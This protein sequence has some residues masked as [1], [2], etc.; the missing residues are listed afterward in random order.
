MIQGLT[1]LAGIL[2]AVMVTINGGLSDTYGVYSATVI[3][4][5][6]GVSFVSVLVAVQRKSLKSGEKLPLHYYLGGAVGVGTVVFNNMA[7]GRISVTAILALSLLGS[8]LCSLVVDQYGWFGMARHPVSAK[9]L[10]GIALAVLGIAWM[11]WPFDMRVVV[12]VIVSLM[13]GVTIV[14]SRSLNARL[15]CKTGMLQSTF[16]NYAVGLTVS[17][18][19]LLIFG[20][21]EPMMA[22]LEFSPRVWIYAGGMLGACIVTL[23]NVVSV[24]LSSFYV[25]LLS[26]VGQIFAGVALDVLLTGAFSLPN[27]IG[28]ILVTAGLAQNLWIDKKER[29]KTSYPCPTE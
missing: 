3:I 22:G 1:V 19:I 20:Q 13:T 14:V 5:T 15:T 26:F 2:I 27:L 6:V 9:K 11:L 10:P 7:F 16:F 29:I 24:K 23:F 25:S 12:P 21:G 28:G 8:V 17:A 4:H 18:A